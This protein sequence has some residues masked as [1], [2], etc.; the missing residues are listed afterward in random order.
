MCSEVSNYSF[1]FWS[2]TNNFSSAERRSCD[3]CRCSKKQCAMTKE[4]LMQQS[5]RKQ[6]EELELEVR[7]GKW[8]RMESVA[9]ESEWQEGMEDRLQRMEDSM[10]WMEERLTELLVVVK[11]LGPRIDGARTDVLRAVHE[12]VD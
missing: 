7:W 11:G 5:K 12:V 6:E 1:F 10:E 3:E 8:R 4:G 9:D 2:L